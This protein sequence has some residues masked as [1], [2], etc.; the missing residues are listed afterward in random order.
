MVHV[1]ERAATGRSQCRACSARIARDELRFGERRDNSF[2][3]GESTVWFHPLCAAYMRPEQLL[4]L[5]STQTLENTGDLRTIAESSIEHPRLP[6]LKS[7]ERSPT[8]RANCRHC[9][10]PIDKGHLASRAAVLRGIPLRCTRLHPCRLHWRILRHH[11]R[12][13]THQALQSADARERRGGSRQGDC[14]RA[15]L[16][17]RRPFG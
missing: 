14:C 11:G 5:L 8:G 12:G 2:G 17:A 10:R 15:C 13:W 7:A 1:M 4:E 9:R 3:E 6:R 16:R